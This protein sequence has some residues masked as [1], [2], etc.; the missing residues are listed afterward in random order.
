MP[1]IREGN[2]QVLTVRTRLQSPVNLTIYANFFDAWARLTTSSGFRLSATRSTSSGGI[3]VML[4][5]AKINGPV[6]KS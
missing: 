3:L 5:M 6:S 1:P 4:M 2:P